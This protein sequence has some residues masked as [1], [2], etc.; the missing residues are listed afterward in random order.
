MSFASDEFD[1]AESQAAP[2]SLRWRSWPLAESWSAAILVAVG[3]LGAGAAVR[4]ATAATHL[5]LLAMAALA[6]AL[7]RFFLPT[8]FEL[9]AEGVSQW[10][11]GRRRRIPWRDIRRYQVCSSGVLLLPQADACPLD[12]YRGLYLPWG[13]HRPEVLA[14]VHYYLDRPAAQ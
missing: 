4:W 8:S 10:L 5:A 3:L 12:A 6:V 1:F 11:F 2:P 9:N 14:H 7:W 13:K